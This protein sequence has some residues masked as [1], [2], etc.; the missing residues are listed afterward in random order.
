[1]SE[2]ATGAEETRMTAFVS[3]RVQGV[4]FR[5]WVRSQALEL[6]LV[7]HAA[8]RYDGKVEVVVQGPSGVVS[9]MLTRLQEFPS[10]HR[11]P[12]SVSA[13]V[14]RYDAARPGVVGFDER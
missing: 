6:G 12:G 1:V 5:W 10:A 4:G 14:V 2:E 11:R 3:G 7:G 13:V 9:E 8:N